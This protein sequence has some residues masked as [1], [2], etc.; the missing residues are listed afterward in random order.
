L[1]RILKSYQRWISNE[2]GTRFSNSNRSSQ[3]PQLIDN[4]PLNILSAWITLEVLS[5]QT[6]RNPKDLAGASGSI[7]VIQ[8]EYLPW[9]GNGE[10]SRPK[11]HLYYQVVLGTIDFEKAVSALQEKY[12]DKRVDRPP[13]KGEAI[14]AV[15]VVDSKGRPIKS[16]GVAVSSFAWGLPKALNGELDKLGNWTEVDKEITNELDQLFRKTDIDGNDLPVDFA[17]IDRARK[18]LIKKLEI[19]SEFITENRFAIRAYQYS[20]TPNPESPEPL[21][22]NSFFLGDLITVYELFSSSKATANLKRYLGVLKPDERK[23]LLHDTETLE[24]AVSPSFIPPGRWPGP[25]RHPLVLLQQ[26]AVNLAM[27]EWRNGGILAVNGPPGTGKTTLLR[28]VVAALVTERAEVMCNFENPADAFT[29][30]EL[31]IKAGQAILRL[32][33]LDPLLKGYEMLIAS[34]NNKAVENVSAELPSIKAIANDAYDLRYFSTLSNAL[35]GRESWG[36]IAAVLGNMNNRSQFRQTFWW[37]KE[38]GFATYL[39]E[40][41]GAPQFINIIDENTGQIIGKRKPAIITVENPPTNKS[42]ALLKWHLAKEKF[43]AVLAKAKSQ[44]SGLGKLRELVLMLPPIQKEL[45]ELESRLS[46]A[47]D[48]V[49]MAKADFEIAISLYNEKD[50]ELKQA[51]DIIKEHRKIRPGLLARFFRTTAFRNWKAQHFDH[52][53]KYKKIQ[54]VSA[55]FFQDAANKEKMIDNLNANLQQ[56]A[57]RYALTSNNF[58]QI[59]NRILQT[60]PSFSGHIIDERLSS[61][62]TEVD[63]LNVPWCDEQTQRLRDEVFLAAIQVHKAFIDAAAIPLK[64]NIGVLMNVFSGNNLTE[65]DKIRLLGDLWSSLFLIVPAVSTTFASVERMLGK[66]PPES[67]GWLLIDEAGQALPQAAIGALMRTRRA[68]IVGDPIQIE[69]VVVLP[70]NLTKNI[71]RRFNVDPDHFNAPEVSTQTL[72]DAATRYYAEFEGRHGSRSVGV[73]L[74]VHRRCSDPMFSISN[75]VA[76]SNLMVQAKSVL[77]S[78]IKNSLGP[79]RWIEVSG[80]ANE[81]WCPEEGQVVLDLLRKLIINNVVP[82]LYIVTPFVIVADNLRKLIVESKILESYTENVIGWCYERVGTVHTVQGREA[83]AVIFV[84]GAPDSNQTGARGW[85][86]QRPNL[87]N[88]AVTRAKEALYVIGNRQLWRNAGF[89]NELA[90]RL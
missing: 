44:L 33:E 71:C 46:V 13:S 66:L 14:L 17:T 53:S 60:W 35:L 51:E 69:P 84:L 83:E 7:A 19:P 67:I 20:A 55:Q 6:F 41:A 74:L 61:P 30:S 47:K 3:M 28:D 88:V 36:I 70:S 80:Q 39:A 24:R 79:S 4:N 85:A 29:D 8:N 45:K 10:A 42:E 87:L 90:N 18:H 68:I 64:H 75:A 2:S 38:L 82:D 72:A 27:Y 78:P 21:L 73:P 62:P 65:T 32:Y 1:K 77:N 43:S 50:Q 25:G 9:S 81:K 58:L 86:G 34:S 76:Y 56:Y 57:N 12:V 22:L 40:A 63:H 26:A 16:P 31:K 11:Y 89:F 37:D 59:K 52:T 23:D 54:T 48:G 49:A 15:L 5:P